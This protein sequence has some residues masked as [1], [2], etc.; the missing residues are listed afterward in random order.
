MENVDD[1]LFQILDVRHVSSPSSSLPYR[2]VR[3]SCLPAPTS[4]HVGHAPFCLLLPPPMQACLDPY[5][6][7]VR[8]H[9]G[10]LFRSRYDD[11]DWS[12]VRS[13]RLLA[14][15][16]RSVGES[17]SCDVQM[18]CRNSMSPL[19]R[20]VGRCTE[21]EMLVVEQAAGAPEPYAFWAKM[22]DL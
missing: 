7:W 21:V 10:C 19:V 22:S 9:S 20:M 11:D 3:A 16:N 17:V 4:L 6:A 5:D 18:E 8:R 12:V 15:S 13:V 14:K 2:G 1:P